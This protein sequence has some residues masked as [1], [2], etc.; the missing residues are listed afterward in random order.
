M[1]WLE[2][3][4]ERA[5]PELLGI[6]EGRP[7]AMFLMREVF[8]GRAARAMVPNL[9]ALCGRYAPD[10]VVREQVE[11]G[12][13]VAAERLGIPHAV[14]GWA[15]LRPREQWRATVGEPLA[16]L[17]RTYDRDLHPEF[18]STSIR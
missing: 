2:S 17:Y 6:P 14:A 7:Q 11:F 13:F 12:G 5:F 3:E 4:A 10:L 18:R 8:A 15:Y 16:A 1:D 9:L